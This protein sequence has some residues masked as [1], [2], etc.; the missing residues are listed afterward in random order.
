MSEC[1]KCGYDLRHL[2]A[3]VCPECGMAG[4]ADSVAA[5]QRRRNRRRTLWAGG[6]LLVIASTCCVTSSLTIA[7]PNLGLPFGYY[8]E[9]NR[10][11]SRVRAIDG[12]RIVNVRANYD[13]S[14]EEFSI[15]V[16]VD[17]VHSASIYFPQVSQSQQ[18]A[19]VD[20][21]KQNEL[22]RIRGE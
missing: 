17:G 9:L 7:G 2:K 12:V 13:L 15:D 11:K 6:A 20:A 1:I 16:I 10:T 4:D 14:I 19:I 8:G 22:P 18:F 3:V 5:F 21:W